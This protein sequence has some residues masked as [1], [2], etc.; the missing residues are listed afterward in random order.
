MK[1]LRKTIYI[2]ILLMISSYAF[3]QSVT[4]KVVD[5]DN[6][7]LVGANIFWINTYQGTQTDIN[8]E[9]ELRFTDTTNKLVVSYIGFSTDTFAIYLPQNITIKLNRNIE[10]GEA[11]IIAEKSGTYFSKINPIKTK[12]ISQGE[13]AKAACCDL[14]GCFGTDGSVQP[15]TTNIVTNSKELRIMGL[16]GVYTQ[17]LIDGVPLI[18]GLTYTYGISSYPG[19]L[20]DK[21]NVAIGANSVLQGFESI[22]GQINIQLKS[23]EK[24][25]K[26]FVNLYA[27]SFLEKQV[28][29]NFS[30]KFKKWNTILA[31]HTTQPS[32][33]FDRDNDLFLDLP[34]LTRYS[35]YN[36]WKKGNAETWGFNSMIGVRYINENRI[37][38][39]LDFDQNAD[40]GSVKNYGQKIAYSQAEVF[41]NTGYRFD[42]KKSIVL[43]SSLVH[44]DQNSIFGR[45]LYDAEQLN[46][47]GNLQFELKWKKKH[48]LKT[49]I[50]VRN[51][52]I[53]ENIVFT[54][55][56]LNKTYDG[57]HLKE[58]T[59]PGIFI[60]NVFHWNERTMLIT[61]I[62]AD[63]NNTFGSFYT[64][65]ALLKYDITENTT[66]RISG[67]T[68]YRTINLFSENV[69]LLASSRD[70]IITE[71]LKPEKAFNWGINLVHHK[72]WKKV[73][74][75]FGLDF[76]RTDFSNQIF[77]DYDSDPTKA[78]ISN[79]RGASVSNGFQA[80]A[81]FNFSK[82]LTLKTSYNY[83]NVYQIID[84]YKKTLP[85]NSKHKIISSIS[86]KPKNKKWHADINLHW[87]GEQVLAKT[88]IINNKESSSNK[89]K[90]YSL[91]NAQFTKTWKR[92]DV[93]IG[94]ENILDFRQERPIIG[95]QY[96][97]GDSFDTSNVWGPTRG[98]EF[99]LGV[100]FRVK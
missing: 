96:P 65:R 52:H 94:C 88:E 17:V 35:F 97:F 60:E 50:S 58:E 11:K 82:K 100:K 95:W 56:S 89:S 80:E 81:N 30:H 40:I 2:T 44:H 74:A 99:Y 34:Q 57:I 68:G 90:P 26:F 36:K 64:P 32:N 24:S 12:T 55:N 51:N 79:F 63:Q 92:F 33:K 84:N 21:I 13:L 70:V 18:Q 7:V 19:T 72:Y 62:R 98:R 54:E 77:P 10:L 15:V 16:S 9:F 22:N 83:L 43:I 42:D 86:Y 20:V 49:G 85:F 38:G 48:L 78:I 27:N 28:N 25:D 39:Q 75:T 73:S 8:G 87:F 69:N 37:G 67:G 5:Q 6:D 4:G 76:Y 14:A 41:T 46:Y 53:E 93:Y 71:E 45:T 91:I 47:Y 66:L 61:G 31:A 59:I 29:V 23:P 3:S 1:N